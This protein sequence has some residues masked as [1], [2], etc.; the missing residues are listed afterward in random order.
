MIAA[1]QMDMVMG[2]DIH[3]I[4]PPG[5]VPPLPIPHPFIG[6]VLDTST[7]GSK[8]LINGM[9][10]GTAGSCIIASP[11][12][13]P[14][15]GMFVP[16]PPGNEGEIYMGS[17]TVLAEGEP[18]SRLGMQALT[19]QTVGMPSFPRKNKS[20]IAKSLML[21][22]SVVLAIPAGM[23]VMVGGPPTIMMAFAGKVNDPKGSLKDLKIEKIA[24]D[25]VGKLL[26][27]KTTKEESD[28]IHAA[29]EAEMD[30]LKISPS[31]REAV[32][33]HICSIT[34]HPVDIASGM[35][36]TET[37]D[38]ELSGSIP[39]RWER[40]WYSTSDFEG[41]LGHGW[42]H[43]YNMALGIDRNAIDSKTGKR[44]SVVVVR[45]PDGR[46]AVFEDIQI[47]E[48]Y[49][50]RKEKLTL[51][52]DEKG[53][54]VQDKSLLNYH[55]E[56]AL[57][58][59]SPITNHQN[60]EGV[61]SLSRIEDL[62]GNKVQFKRNRQ[63]FL[64]DI[65]DSV[66]RNL[67]VETDEKGR[68]LSILAPHPEDEGLMFD[69][70]RYR[71]DAMG[72]LIES[73]DAHD[74]AMSY[75]YQNHW[76]VK[77]TNRNGLNFFFQY[78]GNGTEA[79][80][81]RTWGDGSIYDH[82]LTYH[83][84]YTIVE[85]SLGHEATH[86][87]RGGLVYKEINTKGG[88]TFKDYNEFNDLLSERDPLGFSTN[89]NYDER[90]NQT[91]IVAADGSSVQTVYNELD[92]PIMVTDQVGG[93]WMWNYD[94]KG[95]TISRKNPLEE[96]TKYEYTEGGLLSKIEDA[97][98]GVTSL[99]FDKHQNLSQ[100]TTADGQTYYWTYD[101]LGN[102]TSAVDPKGNTQKRTFD[103]LSQITKVE[104]PDGNV[105]T[106]KYDP[107]GN[108]TQAKDNQ[109]DVAFEY[110]GM[111]RLKARVQN[112]TRVE[113]K[114]DTEEQL[115][116]IIN[117]HGYAYRF[118]L[119]TEGDVIQES[120][121]DSI[122]RIY[123]RDAAGRVTKV[124]RANAMHTLYMYDG[125]GRVTGVNHSDGTIEKFEYRE[126]GELMMAKN[127]ATTVLFER[128]LLGRVLSETSDG[129]TIESMYDISGFR[130]SIKSSLGADLD[131]TRNIMGDVETLRA[132]DF[133]AKFK[134]D[135]L[136]LELERE[137][138]GGVRGRWSRDKLGR[139]IKHELF[140]TGGTAHR[141]RNYSWEINNRLKQLTD[142]SQ[143]TTRYEHDNFGNLAAAINPDGSMDLRMPDAVGNLFR[144]NE[145]NDRRYG[146]AGQ[147]LEANG[148]RYEYDAEG[149]LS[150][151]I[152]KRGQT[153][154]YE[155]NASGM[156][157]RVKR[158]DGGIV[159]MTYDALGRR[160]GKQYGQTINRWAWDG[161][162]PLHEWQEDA[163]FITP[164]TPQF[165]GTEQPAVMAAMLVPD[166]V[167]WVFEAE[168]F[169]PLAKLT[170]NGNFGIITD[171]LGTPL[172]MYDQKGGT[173]W[174]ADLNVYGEI[175]NLRG[176]RED[177]P[178]RYPGQYED[179]ETGLYYNRFR[180]YD[181]EMGGY[182][183]QDPIG[184]LGGTSTYTFVNDP[185]SYVDILGLSA[186][187]I[188]IIGGPQ[189]RVNQIAELL[190]KEGKIVHTITDDW[191]ADKIFIPYIPEKHD[192]ISVQYNRDWINNKMDEGVEIYDIGRVGESIWYKAEHEEIM[193]R[194]YDKHYAFNPKTGNKN[195]IKLKKCGG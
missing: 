50:D 190:R 94:N 64:T 189:K 9:P 48:S 85:N 65:I 187:P 97:A 83:E 177:C 34:G 46:P 167:T 37:V 41:D 157:Q 35:V 58:H 26:K 60:T 151:K 143:G 120:G 39:L 92:L 22:T 105:R 139:P 174:S 106:L 28:K 158:P 47:G 30:R 70:V 100:A 145:R 184:L 132:N 137:M 107:E 113:F 159:T 135:V 118:E 95:N 69:I 55:F 191:P 188:I 71:Y 81:S 5:P 102:C 66:G 43:N 138:S 18:L 98:K 20:S 121:F 44:R 77:E 68:I 53:Y 176:A 19:C 62:N 154:Q 61:F 152:E 57:N 101:N 194:G 169:S 112:K 1:K 45:M 136:G 73:L 29:A 133:T 141:T 129:N 155:W 149:N 162:V 119:D 49:F 75:V 4:Q 59:Q 33:K 67:S 124:K 76:L 80:C 142:T 93:I 40:T 90:A 131:F 126:D 125:V 96:V 7:F 109:Y 150:K 27:G 54:Y 156:L 88:I 170:A 175:R 114:Y 146:P 127:E 38:F 144:T 63:G 171:H 148:V 185:N 12:H 147:L 31:Q 179:V 181:A 78:F 111:N 186:N 82:K 84:G 8:V 42:H 195:K 6:M 165:K 36:F 122:R 164:P 11:P 153:W 3:M 10:C 87:H 16:P 115:L 160:I 17:A 178:F 183:S 117:E 56:T 123:E 166:I 32:H 104:E 14:I 140:G 21:P 13:I 168:S 86:Y 173:V 116:G 103:L 72:N 128:D 180:Y 134:R 130:K 24:H 192:A 99:V 74:Q 2:V 51:F 163:A 23:P 52:R 79:K 110:A 25:C 15:G 108:I 193:K 172:S 161:N 91:L 89:Y 182:L